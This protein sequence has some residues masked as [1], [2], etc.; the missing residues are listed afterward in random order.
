MFKRILVPTDF[1]E[2]AEHALDIAI[3]LATK[4]GASITLLHAYQLVLPVAYAEAFTWPTEEIEK[5]ARK[6]LD[7]H[8]VRA[9]ARYS[10][11]E[12]MLKP[13]TAAVEIVS[14]ANQLKADLIVMG[15]HGR[16]GPSRLMLGSVA[17]RV[18]RT[19]SAPVLTVSARED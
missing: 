4:F 6:T 5:E 3:E 12:A 7:A 14:V 9:K 18:L 11:C 1:G 17:D 13:G 15:T 2:P 19:A 16:R 8:L 10:D